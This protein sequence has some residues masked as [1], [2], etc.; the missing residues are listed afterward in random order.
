M[1]TIADRDAGRAPKRARFFVIFTLVPLLLLAAE[2]F[3][4]P[5]VVP[6][7][8]LPGQQYRLAFVTAGTRS[9]ISTSI[10]SYDAFVTAEANTE[11][12]LSS[13]SWQVIASTETVSAR[14]HTATDPASYPGVPIFLLNDVKLV[15][16]YEDLWDGSVD[17]PLAINQHGEFNASWPVWTGTAS[18]GLASLIPLGDPGEHSLVGSSSST[19]STWIEGVQ[20]TNSLQ[21]PFYAISAVLTVPVPE[22]RPAAMLTPILA[23]LL[24][25]R[26]LRVK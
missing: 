22:S 4:A 23:V 9:A 14:D 18:T 17:A 19:A 8:L 1:L 11:A 20:Q 7:T 2:S 5:I 24:L 16:D 6:T 12:A 13:I 15:D 26:R 25:V 21:D 10:D 3:A